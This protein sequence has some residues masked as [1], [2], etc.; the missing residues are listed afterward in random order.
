[1]CSTLYPLHRKL[2]GG[3][4]PAFQRELQQNKCTRPWDWTLCHHE[5]RVCLLSKHGTIAVGLACPCSCSLLLTLTQATP[6]PRP[7]RVSPPNKLPD[8]DPRLSITCSKVRSVWSVLHVVPLDLSVVQSPG[9]PQC[10]Q[11]PALVTPRP[12][13][14][15]HLTF[16]PRTISDPS[17]QAA[18]ES[19]S[20][21]FKPLKLKTS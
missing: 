12:C 14:V 11:H 17:P 9:P 13:K 4:Q 18:Q 16:P 15:Q 21:C 8:M 19:H 6:E 10:W 1:M 20:C 3:E 7:A 2:W 5:L